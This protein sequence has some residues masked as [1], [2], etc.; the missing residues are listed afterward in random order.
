M[1]VIWITR[2]KLVLWFKATDDGLALMQGLCVH[3]YFIFTVVWVISIESPNGCGCLRQRS[4]KP[5]PCGMQQHFHTNL[6]HVYSVQ[7]IKMI[8]Q[9]E[10]RISFN[11]DFLYKHEVGG[12]C[13]G[14]RTGIRTPQRHGGVWW[15][16]LTTFQMFPLSPIFLFPAFHGCIPVR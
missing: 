12:G 16:N 4:C 10:W 8:A 9:R 1:L 15:Q 14:G 5:P 6:I 13:G 2:R 11:W 7:I 3:V